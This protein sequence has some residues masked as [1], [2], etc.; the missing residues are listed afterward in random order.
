VKYSFIYIGALLLSVTACRQHSQSMPATT[1]STAAAKDSTQKA[2]FPVADYIRGEMHY[3]DSMPLAVLEYRIR[4]NHTDSSFIHADEFHRIAGEFLLPDLEK[5]NFEKKYSEN[6]FM[7]ETSG[8]LTFTYSP[9]DKE[10]PL[11][12]VD[13]LAIPASSAAGAA[14]I[15]S[16]YLQ[17]VQPSADTLIVKKMLWIA[18]KSLLIIT[19]LQ[20]DGKPPLI[21]QVKVVWDS[22]TGE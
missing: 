13:V 22:S 12:R 17:T 15:K 10:L 19:S 7:D 2:F 21:R 1:D 11:Q 3:V 6:S 16:I 8:Y 14:R 18:K 9:R 5:E 4:D 20:P